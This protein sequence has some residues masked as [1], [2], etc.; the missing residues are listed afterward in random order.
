[1]MEVQ[2]CNGFQ[3]FSFQL[4]FFLFTDI[5]YVHKYVAT[6]VTEE[7]AFTVRHIC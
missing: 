2:T 5:L 4:S 6:E 1:M 3:L 7:L